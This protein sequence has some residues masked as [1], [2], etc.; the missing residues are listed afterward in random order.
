MSANQVTREDAY[1]Q[2]NP[3]VFNYDGNRREGYR[4]RTV[5]R[6][7]RVETDSE[8][9]LARVRNISDG[10]MKLSHHLPLMLGDTVRVALTDEVEIEGKVVWTNGNDCGVQF[11]ER[12]D[13]IAVLRDTAERM[14]SASA[15]APRIQTEILAIASSEGALQAVAIQDVSLRGMKI[16]HN[17]SFRSGLPVKVCLSSG[18]ERR[19][20]VR[21]ANDRLAGLELTEPFGVEDL[22]AV[23]AL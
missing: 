7:V 15:R 22:G 10:G 8:Q 12:I 9:G 1:P 19:G 11:P 5:Y 23:S 17:G 21:W 6:V 14:R 20:I 4:V 18:V 3:G 16:A 13:S 2:F